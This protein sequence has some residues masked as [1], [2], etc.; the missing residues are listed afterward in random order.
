M[1]TKW[2][3]VDSPNGLTRSWIHCSLAI[4]VD[5]LAANQI[6]FVTQTS[7]QRAHFCVS[8]FQ[9]HQNNNADQKERI[10]VTNNRGVLF[11]RDF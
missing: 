2:I 8:P 3:K 4:E 10:G 5:Q 11:W 1:C 6:L 9:I 7:M